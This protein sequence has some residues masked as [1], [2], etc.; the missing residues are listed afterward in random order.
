[1]YKSLVLILA[2]A[3][4]SFLYA[5]NISVNSNPPSEIKGQMVLPFAPN[6]MTIT[7]SNDPVT[8]TAGNS[9]SCNA[10]APNYYH[11]DNSYYR[12][13]KMSDFGITQDFT[14]SAVEIG[15]EQ[16]TGNTGSQ[17]IECK[18]YTTSSTFPAGFP[19]SLTQIASVSENIPDQNLTL[20]SF[21]VS[22]LVPAGTNQL[23]VEVHAPDGQTTL[24]TFFIGSNAGG[25]SA[26]SY[27][28]AVDCSITNPVTT[29]SIGF[30]TMNIVMSVTGSENVPV[31]L[32]SFNAYDVR[33]QVN[34]EWS[35]STETNNR[36]FE[37]QKSADGQN[38]NTVGFIKGHGTS[39]EAHSYN[40]VDKNVVNGTVSY[41]LKQVD[42][43]G[44]FVYSDVVTVNVDAPAT[45]QLS[46][47]FPNPF[48]PTTQISFA[49][50]VD[51]GVKISVYNALG[52]EMSKVVN[53]T[54]TAG[55]HTINFNA[56]NLSS[57]LYF[58]TLEA[59]GVDGSSYLMSK[60]MM[61][62]K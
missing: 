18:L 47:N 21:N 31:E 52:Q 16:A 39:T 41:R 26:P 1:M 60:K 42:F 48:N 55:S 45:Y 22:G 46:Q 59:K 13:F 27:L 5:Q 10:G 14:V 37:I 25:E 8:I 7:E 49:L 2:L 53:N 38:Y 57:G 61:L 17:P 44:A 50:P 40:F 23:V 34:I 62:M 30:G 24:N 19:G 6:S 20:Y 56:S 29:G 33:G 9:V 58:Y 11:T 54:F 35:T 3:F 28:K 12:A 32:S 51:A 36:G 43:N 4:G 15:I